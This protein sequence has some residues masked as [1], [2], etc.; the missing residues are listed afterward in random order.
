MRWIGL[1]L[2]E[3]KHQ[4]LSLTI[5]TKFQIIALHNTIHL[6]F[7]LLASTAF[8]I[9]SIGSSIDLALMF[10]MVSGVNCSWLARY[11]K[12]A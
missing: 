1:Y 12:Y 4:S 7:F 6:L 3:A 10:R 5:I 9:R 8:M 2:Y 11:S